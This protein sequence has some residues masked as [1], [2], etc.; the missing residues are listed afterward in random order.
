M[1]LPEQTEIE[2][3]DPANAS[4]VKSPKTFSLSHYKDAESSPV[5]QLLSADRNNSTSESGQQLNLIQAELVMSFSTN[6]IKEEE[7][8]EDCEEEMKKIPV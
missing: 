4:L 7:E 6:T 2:E 8:P 5:S 3:G 1:E